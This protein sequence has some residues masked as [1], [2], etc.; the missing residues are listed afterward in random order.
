MSKK[1]ISL[2][3]F[4]TCLSFFLYSQDNHFAGGARSGGM[5][6]ASV[7]IQDS[8]AIFN[9]PAALAGLEHKSLGVFYENRF[10][11]Q[12][13][14]RGA[15]LYTSPLGNG[16]IGVGISHFGFQLFQSNKIGLA[17][18]MQ[19][20]NSVSMGIQADYISAFQSDI[21]GNLHALTFDIGLLATPTEEFAIGF[22]AFNP[23][24]L[25]YFDD[26]VHKMPI[27]FKL[28]FSYLFNNQLLLALETGK[29]INGFIP[30][31][32]MGI[33]YNIMD[34][35][36]LRTGFSANNG[37]EYS[38]GLGYM[39]EQLNF[40]LAFAYHQ[41]LGNTPKVSLNYVF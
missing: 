26:N 23:L 18:A 36:A 4:L 21:Y 29:A 33:E 12:A 37:I 11:I 22:H 9:N 7:T 16:N 35:F 38:F 30:I 40:D 20:F 19:L 3:L 15:L 2:T 24:N 1:T 8:W 28:G 39:M 27:I 25:S 13:T 31:F 17:Y 34:S 14:G 32:K 41:I 6:D 5:S 10:L